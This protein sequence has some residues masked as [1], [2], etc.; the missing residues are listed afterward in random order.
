V[1]TKRPERM[2]Q[3]LAGVAKCDHG[4]LT[5]NGDNPTS[6]GGTGFILHDHHGWPLPNVWL[7]TSI[8]NRRYVDRADHLRA[9]PAAVRFISAEPL[10][11]PLIPDG[12]VELIDTAPTYGPL[13]WADGMTT[14]EN[15]GLDLD[16][17]DWLIV[18]GESGT[19]HRPIKEEWVRDLLDAAT[20][21]ETAFFLKQ[22]GGHTP[23]AGGRELD[24]RTFD[25]FPSAVS[26]AGAG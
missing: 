22:W 3:L 5:H 16:D 13:T 6:Y 7:G 18:G 9:T 20:T 14:D 4:W 21:T 24:G 15:L 8:E 25:E 19:G 10:L 26:I 2:Q 23:K 11:G 1:L 17:I 12:E